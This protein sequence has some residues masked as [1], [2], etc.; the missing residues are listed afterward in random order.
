MKK[1]G[2]WWATGI[3]GICGGNSS[4]SLERRPAARLLSHFR[5]TALQR[6][7]AELTGVRKVW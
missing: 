1:A 2:D 7:R 3:C 5:E 4:V 6:K